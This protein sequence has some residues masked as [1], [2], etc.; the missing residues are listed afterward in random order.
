MRAGKLEKKRTKKGNVNGPSTYMYKGQVKVEE[1]A[2]QTTYSP[3][4]SQAQAL[5]E[6]LLKSYKEREEMIELLTKE[7][8]LKESQINELYE[9]NHELRNL[10]EKTNEALIKQNKA[11]EDMKRAHKNDYFKKVRDVLAV[12]SED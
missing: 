1:R 2:T 5:V 4:Y 3:T 8:K 9:K 12:H 11:I 6:A 7:I 10:L